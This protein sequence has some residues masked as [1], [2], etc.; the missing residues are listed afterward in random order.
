MHYLDID[1]A[2]DKH[3]LCLM[4]PDGR[5]LFQFKITHDM[6]GFS[7]LHTLLK[8]LLNLYI[9]IERSDGLFV[10]WL[11]QQDCLF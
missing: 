7:K 11:I 10:D 8:T 1:W 3:D 2:T 4:A 5:V 6:A 9:N